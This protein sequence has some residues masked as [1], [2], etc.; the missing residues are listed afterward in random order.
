MELLSGTGCHA[1]S[2]VARSE[3]GATLRTGWHAQSWVAR[4]E[5]AMGVVFLLSNAMSALAHVQ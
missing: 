4:P 2:W 1:Q 3:L 5:L